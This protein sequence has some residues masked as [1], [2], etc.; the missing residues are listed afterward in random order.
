VTCLGFVYGTLAA[1]RR[2]QSRD[3]GT[4]TQIGSAL[5]YR[6][7]PLQSAYCGAKAAIRGFTDSVRTELMHDGSHVRLGMLQ[8]PAVNTPQPLRQRNKMG[9]Q[10]RPVPPMFSPESI[11]RIVVWA[12]EHPP[13]EVQIGL[14]V[15]RAV[16]AQKLMPGLADR[17]AAATW[18]QQMVDEFNMQRG[19]ILFETLPGDP[20]VHGPYRSQERGP[21]FQNADELST[22]WGRRRR[23]RSASPLSLLPQGSVCWRHVCRQ[24]WLESQPDE[25]NG[26]AHTSK[27]SRLAPAA[28]V[29]SPDPRRRVCSLALAQ[30]LS[31]HRSSPTSSL[32]DPDRRGHHAGPTRPA[33]GHAHAGARGG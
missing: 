23:L 17:L 19:D 5:A 8:L 32:S 15:V 33:A 31:A 22:R 2:M 16:L 14:P 20:G 11:A 21:V 3:E 7:I 29:E 25:L 26:P 12:A 28:D 30:R 6:S 13:R 1:L 4:I 10:P 9:W 18:E 27:P 24:L